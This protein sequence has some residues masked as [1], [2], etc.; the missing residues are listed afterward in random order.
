ADF[1]RSWT[2]SNILQPL[3]VEL[4]HF[5]ARCEQGRV[6][7]AWATG[8][9]R[10]A[11]R[12]VVERSADGIAYDDIG[13]VA[14]TGSAAHYAYIDEQPL[15]SGFYRIRIVD[16][17]GS[18]TWGPVAATSCRA[19]ALAIVSAWDDGD[20]L[21]VIVSSPREQ[22][23]T[24]RLFDGAGRLAHE[25]QGLRLQAGLGAF[26]IDQRGMAMGVYN[27]SIAAEDG[28]MARRVPIY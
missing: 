27:L 3:P 18:S 23:A 16:A 10:G 14:A 6:H 17:D 2:L 9:E 8:A 20:M 1:F 24:V 12:F 15:A 26:A 25:Q 22:S 19:G 4:L 5:E 21:R 28:P 13:Q 11:S 7:L